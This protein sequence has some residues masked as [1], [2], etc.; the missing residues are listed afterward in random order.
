MLLEDC[1]TF[2]G[3]GALGASQD[4]CEHTLEEDI[5]VP[6]PFLSSLSTSCLPQVS[7]LIYHIHIHLQIAAGPRQWFK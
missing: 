5:G 4:N 6:D 2:F 1:T 3:S 7:N